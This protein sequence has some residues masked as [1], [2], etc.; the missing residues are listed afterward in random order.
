MP[1]GAQTILVQEPGE[2]VI[3]VEVRLANA[4]HGGGGAATAQFWGVLA[5]ALDPLRTF[6]PTNYFISSSGGFVPPVIQT[7]VIF[8]HNDILVGTEGTIDFEDTV[9]MLWTL[10]DDGANGRVKVAVN[11]N[12]E[13]DYVESFASTNIT[14][15]T[16]GTAQ[17]IIT[18]NP[19]TFGAG[20]L[21][22]IEYFIPRVKNTTA[23]QTYDIHFVFFDSFVGA[24]VEIAE[25]QTGAGDEH[26]PVYLKR[27]YTP[28]AGVHTFSLRAFVS[29]NAATVDTDVGNWPIFAHVGQ[30]C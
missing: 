16:L 19:I 27:R 24:G 22:N 9:P 3:K 25:V 8:Q 18:S 11:P 13:L 21:V 23:G 7:P 10:T 30:N 2:P 15:V 29:A 6:I 17:T 28:A 20:A 14:A 5:T 26:L 4:V 12:L 1:S